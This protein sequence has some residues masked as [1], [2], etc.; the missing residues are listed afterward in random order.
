MGKTRRR[1]TPQQKAAIIREHL[2]DHVPVSDLCDQHGIHPTMFYR[3][4]KEV[5][6]NLPALF[7][8]KKDSR[9]SILEQENEALRKKCSGK[10]EII[11]E[12]MEDLIAVKKKNG[13]LS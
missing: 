12:I 3:W 6:E 1:L 5:F 4:Q 7:E 9:Q 11:A 8:K 13:G 10:D 2:V